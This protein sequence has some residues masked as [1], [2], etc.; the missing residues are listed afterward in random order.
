MAKL[1]NWAEE[2]REHYRRIKEAGY[3][4][5]EAEKVEGRASIRS[6]FGTAE[7]V[8]SRSP[9]FIWKNPLTHADTRRTICSEP[10]WKEYPARDREMFQKE[11]PMDPPD[12]EK[13]GSA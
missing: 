8:P 9:S 10:D 2:C 5:T 6:V 1:A 13:G 11:V 4:V 3:R 7:P 12:S